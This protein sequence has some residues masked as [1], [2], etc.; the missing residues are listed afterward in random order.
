[1]QSHVIGG[2]EP[3]LA[4]IVLYCIVHL[5]YSTVLWHRA[6]QSKFELRL[7]VSLAHH[8]AAH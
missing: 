4:L 2:S 7:F 1:M 3:K 5:Q 6:Q 8:E